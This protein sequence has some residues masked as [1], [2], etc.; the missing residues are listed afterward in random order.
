M[1]K[2][3]YLV[4]LLLPWPVR[5]KVLTAA[6]GFKIH[7]TA[8]IRLAWVMPKSLV[9][10]ANSTIGSFSVCR[11]LDRLTLGYHASIGR[12]NWISGM[13]IHQAAHFGHQHGRASELLMGDHSAVTSRHIIDCTNRVSI[14]AFSTLAGYCTQILTHSIDLDECRQSSAPVTIGEYA[15]VGTSCT[16]LPGSGLPDGSVLGA[17]SLLNKCYLATSWLYGGVPARPIKAIAGGKY[18]S[19]TR[20]F[21]Q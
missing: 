14:G 19:R 12:G 2:L 6:F 10:E 17:K 7:P 15:F 20:G 3:I 9:M 11:G 13:S 8:R 18:F 5:R 16:L 21:V 1:R 4:A